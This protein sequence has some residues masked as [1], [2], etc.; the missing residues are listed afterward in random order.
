MFLTATTFPSPRQIHVRESNV[1]TVAVV[2]VLIHDWEDKKQP[3]GIHKEH[4]LD[5]FKLDPTS[6]AHA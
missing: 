4:W 3:V 1:D 6:F 5:V 2:G